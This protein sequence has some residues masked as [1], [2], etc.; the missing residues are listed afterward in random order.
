[1]L[2]SKFSVMTNDEMKNKIRE[3]NSMEGMKL[4]LGEYIKIYNECA[5]YNIALINWN[6]ENK[7][8]NQN[9]PTTV[10]TLTN[11]NNKKQKKPIVPLIATENPLDHEKIIDI[12]D[13]Y[14]MVLTTILKEQSWNKH[15]V[16]CNEFEYGVYFE[17][18]SIMRALGYTVAMSD[19]THMS[20]PDGKILIS[21]KIKIYLS[22]VD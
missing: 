12:V 19:H 3:N 1:M 14:N 18:M 10:D 15:I 7:N 11:I 22:Y 17:L 8:L 21:C 2:T 4:R 20:G 13:L 6:T 16:S 9:S 5:E